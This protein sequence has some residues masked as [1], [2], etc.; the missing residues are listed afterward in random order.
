[1]HIT[2]SQAR[3]FGELLWNSLAETDPFAFTDYMERVETFATVATDYQLS[4]ALE[5]IHE[6]AA[7][8]VIAMEIANR[9]GDRYDMSGQKRSRQSKAG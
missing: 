4:G 2:E 1:M 3:L 5:D 8:D 6:D 7:R 9:A